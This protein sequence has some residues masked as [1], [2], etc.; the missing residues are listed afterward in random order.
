VALQ[1]RC[2]HRA[3]RLS[4]G[5]LKSGKIQCSYHGWTYDSEGYVVQ[6]PAEAYKGSPSI[7]KK[8]LS[9]RVLKQD[10]YYYIN[11]GDKGVSPSLPFK[12][13]FYKAKGWTHIRLKN[14]FDN[15][16]TNCV[17]NFVDVPHTVFVHPKIF[18]NAQGDKLKA[19]IERSQGSVHVRYQNEKANLGIFSWFLN[20]TKS[21]IQHTDSFHMPNVTSVDYIFS[22]SRRF[23]ITSQSIPVKDDKTVVY[24][25]LTY[26]YG[27][28]N[29]ISRPIVRMQA[30]AIIDQ[31]IEILANQMEVIKKYGA[32]FNSTDSDKIHI[33]IETIRN[34]LEKG[35]D[36]RLLPDKR[37]EIEFQV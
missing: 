15:N 28:W 22:K 11:M 36:P 31:D 9:Y 6:I 21:E 25:D 16:V 26:N 2:L 13:P 1:D 24:T 14:E 17:E 18:R 19:I 3:S 27:F 35:K 33:L 30:Q 20:P 32:Q 12:I 4:R 23:I 7:K 34:D 10:G 5:C 29:T 37:Y 8:A